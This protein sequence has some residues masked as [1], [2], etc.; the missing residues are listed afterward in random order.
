MG[1][2]KTPKLRSCRDISVLGNTSPVRLV[3]HS[4]YSSLSPN[5]IRSPEHQLKYDRTSPFEQLVSPVSSQQFPPPVRGV[6][7][8]DTLSLDSGTHSSPQ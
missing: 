8:G 6:G 1:E 5:L 2:G 4:T 7:L 3:R